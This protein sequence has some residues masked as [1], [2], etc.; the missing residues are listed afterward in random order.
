MGKDGGW[1]DGQL[2]EYVDK[3]VHGQMEDGWVIQ[4]K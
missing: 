3:E 1:R 2:D 4:D